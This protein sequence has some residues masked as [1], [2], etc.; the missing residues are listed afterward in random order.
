M[1]VFFGICYEFI[2][3]VFRCIGCIGRYNRQGGISIEYVLA[4]K[5]N[6]SIKGG[7]AFVGSYECA[8]R[9]DVYKDD[10]GF[11]E[12]LLLGGTENAEDQYL[13]VVEG[14]GGGDWRAFL[15]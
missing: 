12:R 3:E 5:I 11:T 8:R 15:N 10:A 7:N 9:N 2:S 4:I 1:E 14:N 13:T 6:E